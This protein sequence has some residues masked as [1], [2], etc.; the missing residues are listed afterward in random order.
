MDFS[1]AIVTGFRKFVTFRGRAERAEYWLWVLFSV[2]VIIGLTFVDILVFGISTG[3]L[4]TIATLALILPGL[5]AT[6]RRLHDA[7]RPAWWIMLPIGPLIGVILVTTVVAS[8]LLLVIAV[9]GALI[10]FIILLLM[11]VTPGTPG[12]NRFGSEPD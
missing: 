10:G 11:M 8:P 3:P 12:P 1:E 5:A 4:S 2:L 7:D 6:A 9:A